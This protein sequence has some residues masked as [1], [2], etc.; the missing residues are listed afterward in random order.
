VKLSISDPALTVID[1]LGDPGLGG[2]IRF[3]ADVFLS[4]CKSEFRNF[5]LL[6]DYARR[7]GNGAVFKRLGFLLERLVPDEK[8]TLSACQSEVTKGNTR[9]D[10]ALPAVRLI[11]KWRLWVPEGWGEGKNELFLTAIARASFEP[12][13]SIGSRYTLAVG[14]KRIGGQSTC[15]GSWKRFSRHTATGVRV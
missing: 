12:T 14:L 1:M 7:M 2:G 4:Y 9:L 10:P 11:T 6:I 15:R 8:A 3:T 13:I 5:E